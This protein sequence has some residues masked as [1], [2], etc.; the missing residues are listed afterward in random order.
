MIPSKKTT[1][2]RQLNADRQ[3]FDEFRMRAVAAAAKQPETA[4]ITLDLCE[5]LHDADKGIEQLGLKSV[6]DLESE[7]KGM[8]RV[9]IAPRD[10]PT[11]GADALVEL[12]DS[13]G[14]PS[15]FVDESLRDVSQSFAARED[16]DGTTWIWFHLLCKTLAV[17]DN[18]IAPGPGFVEAEGKEAKSRQAARAQSQAN[19]SWIKTGIVLKIRKQS[20]DPPPPVRTSSSDSD[21]TLAPTPTKAAVELICFGAPSTLRDRIRALTK[22][23]SCEALLEDPHMLL[24]LVF[25]EMYKLLDWTAWAVSDTFGPL[26]TELPKDLFTGL[27]NLAK[28]AIYLH[29]NC[30]AALATLNDLYTHHTALMGTDPNTLQRQTKEA[31]KYRQTLFE[32]TQ[33]RLTSLNARISNIIGLSFNIVTQGDSKLMQ[34]ENQSMKTIAVMTLWFMPLGT[35]ASI[36]GSQFMKLQDEWPHHITVSQDFWLMWGM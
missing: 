20:D 6:P 23:T 35:V 8:V 27:H 21:K 7:S 9:I 19:F 28:H 30:E 33:R 17:I 25:E 3:P 32:S 15:A 12:F 11:P 31:L 24:E 13:C 5:W 1:L 14:I 29:E 2:C 10:T 18:K 34:S 4:G 22:T 26:E 36:F 16:A